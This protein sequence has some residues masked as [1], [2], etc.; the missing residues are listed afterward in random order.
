MRAASFYVVAVH[1]KAAHENSDREQYKRSWY[2]SCFS[3]KGE[4]VIS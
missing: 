4:I 3:Q 2:C 1:R